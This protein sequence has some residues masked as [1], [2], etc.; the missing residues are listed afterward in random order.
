MS[1]AHKSLVIVLFFI[2]PVTTFSQTN[3]H[4]SISLAAMTADGIVLSSDSRSTFSDRRYKP[5]PIIGHYDSSQKIFTFPNF[6]ISVVGPALINGSFVSY[7]MNEFHK[8]LDNTVLVD[9]AYD[10]FKAYM[11]RYFPIFY[12]SMPAMTF[13]FCGFIK[14]GRGIFSYEKGEPSPK[15]IMTQSATDSDC[16]FVNKENPKYYLNLSSDSVATV[17]IKS[18]L[19]LEKNKKKGYMFGGP[20]VV[21]KISEG[22]NYNYIKSEKIGQR[23]NTY[24]DFIDSYQNKNVRM[25]FTSNETKLFFQS[26]M[27]EPCIHK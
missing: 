22:N 16:V 12:D 17:M 20:I 15:I 21:L 9:G 3:V 19:N 5:N 1:M 10:V 27:R 4:G 13:I 14:D 26:H 11:S 24:C 23:W 25:H 18:I 8:S 6:A 7:Y 2:S